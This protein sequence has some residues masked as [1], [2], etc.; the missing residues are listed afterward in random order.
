M[1]DFVV[2][3]QMVVE[4]GRMV[5]IEPTSGITNPATWPGTLEEDA[6]IP[7]TLIQ[8]DDAFNAARV[9]LGS[10]GAVY[11]VVLSTDQKFWLREVRRL[12][13]WSE[14][15]KP[16]GYLDR[17]IHGLPVYPSGPSPECSWR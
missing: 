12:I 17:V 8:D 16:G 9:P 1:V 11:A 14:L 6:S 7:V 4:G 13:K 2:S 10:M 15:K 3:F 5:Q